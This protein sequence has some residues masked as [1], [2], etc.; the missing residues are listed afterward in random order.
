MQS[1]WSRRCKGRKGIFYILE[2]KGA[3]T[4]PDKKGYVKHAPGIFYRN[5]RDENGDY[6][7]PI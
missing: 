3:D 1:D 4:I 5:D 7:Y 6:V 2:C